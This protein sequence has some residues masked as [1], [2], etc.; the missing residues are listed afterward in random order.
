MTRLWT[1]VLAA[2]APILLVATQVTAQDTSRFQW[3]GEIELG[4]ESVLS[5]TAAANEISNT[6]LTLNLD[7]EYAISETVSVFGGLTLESLTDPAAD[8]AFKDMGLYVRVL[9]LSFAVGDNLTFAVGKIEPS[10]GTVWDTAA[11]FFGAGLAEDYQLVE[12]LGG[13]A[14][15]D[16]GE[17]GV[18][19][20]GVFFADNTALSKS[21]GFKRG[22]TT[23]SA[24]GA[25][26]TGKLDNVSL[27]WM[28][29]WDSTYALV[30]MRHLS[31][32]VGDVS[33][34]TGF[35]AGLGHTFGTDFNVVAEFASF[36]GFG[37]TAD[38]A[39]FATLNAFY[40]IGDLTLSGTYAHR[41][42]TSAGKT[43]SVSIAAEYEFSDLISLG[44]GLARVDDAGTKDTIFGVNLIFS[45]GGSAG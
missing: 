30:G 34:E 22:Q 41:D 31:A 5:S 45:F 11:G 27:Q 26:N 21:I 3:E 19:S 33:S 35:V 15:L 23:T 6:Y 13:L 32:G 12:Q 36:D 16:M 25:G 40:S 42:V 29:E 14:D 10:F 9:G 8:R 28:K 20:L 18:L 7:G 2:S 24:G 17:A 43:K 39:T 37:G 44:A 38:D 4:N 1:T